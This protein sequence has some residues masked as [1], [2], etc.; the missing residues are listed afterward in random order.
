MKLLYFVC[1]I[2]L[3]LPSLRNLVCVSHAEARGSSIVVTLRDF[4]TPLRG[5]GAGG[6][7][8]GSSREIAKT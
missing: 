6:G 1:T 3:W 5:G 4:I 8:S 2:P 7:S